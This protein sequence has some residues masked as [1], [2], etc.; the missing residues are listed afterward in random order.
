MQGLESLLV[1][2]LVA[3]LTPMIVAAIPG[4]GIPQVV[5]LILAGILIGPHGLGLA[6]TTGIQLLSNV[7]LGFLFLLAGYELDPRLLRAHAASSTP[8]ATG[9]SSPSSSWHRAWPSMSSR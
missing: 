7:G 3:A 4:P 2:T 5:I 9:S 8:S 6:D 1:V